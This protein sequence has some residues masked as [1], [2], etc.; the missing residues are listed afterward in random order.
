MFINIQNKTTGRESILSVPMISE[1]EEFKAGGTKIT[2]MNGNVYRAESPLNEFLKQAELGVIVVKSVN[3]EETED[4]VYVDESED[5]G[6]VLE[7][8]DIAEIASDSAIRY[9]DEHG[10]DITLVEP[11]TSG[12]ITKTEV[13]KYQNENAAHSEPDAAHSEESEG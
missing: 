6:Q 9:A 1:I 10:I 11:N 8:S 2:M 7:F 5:T 3:I 13:V 4:S 12:K